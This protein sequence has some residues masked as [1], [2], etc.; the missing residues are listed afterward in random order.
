MIEA[1]ELLRSY[2]QGIRRLSGAKSVSLFVPASLSGL[3][4]PILIHEGESSPVP[5]LADLETA[6]KS[7]QRGALPNRA[8]DK[9]DLHSATLLPSS[10][11]DAA[12]IPLPSVHSVW[13]VALLPE[14]FVQG[15]PQG[16]RRSDDSRSEAEGSPGAWLGIH[17]PPGPGS[18]LERLTRRNLTTEMDEES[19]PAHWWEWL[20]ALGGALASH[21][22][23]ISAILKDPVTG[24]SDRAGFQA[25][26][27]EELSKSRLASR[28]LSLLL[29]NPDEFALVN[30][31]F[32]REA[33]DRIVREISDRLS[34]TLRSSD[35]VARYGG[36]IFG[37][38]LPD[39][40]L[41]DARQV[42]DKI[43]AGVTEAAFLDGAV[44]LGFSIGIAIFDPTEDAVQ[45]PLD[46]IRRADQA[47]NAA[48]RLGGG[49]IIDWEQRSGAEE[50]GNFD[51][52]S[53]IFTGNMT[54]DY[55]NMV[56]LWDTIDVITVNP[57]FQDLASQV[58]EKLYSSFK[59]VRVAL[60]SL[61]DEGQLKLIRGL[62]RKSMEPGAQPRV[63]T[64]E[65]EPEQRELMS[66][67]IA[68]AGPQESRLAEGNQAAYAVPLIASNDCLGCLYLDGWEDSLALDASDL[69]FLKALA[70]QLAVALDR[71][72]L[73]ELES[74]RREQER[75]QLRAELNELRQALQQAKLV[76]RSAEMG[77]LVATARRVAPTDATV[78]IT[79]ASGTGKELLART[80]HEL[81]PRAGKPLVIVDCGAISTTL[82]ESE[83]FGHEKGAYT[84]AQQRRGGRLVEANHGTVLLDEIGDLPLE[85][86]SKLLRFVQEK[87]FTTVGGSRPR[88]VDVRIVTATNQDLAKAVAAGR[89]REDLYYRL[90]VVRLNVPPLAQRPD[91]IVHLARHF[92]ETFTVQYHKNIRQLTPAA[93]QHLLQHPWPG[94]VRELQNRMMQA[95]ILCE[96]DEIG[97][98]EL[99]LPATRE[100]STVPLVATPALAE[101]VPSVPLPDTPPPHSPPGAV[102]ASDQ[103]PLFA[104]LKDLLQRALARQIEGAADAGTGMVLPLGKWLSDDVIL[105]ADAAANGLARRGAAIVGIP[106]T[107]Y[108]RRLQRA[109]AQERAGLSPRSGTWNEVRHILSEI[110]R[111]GD[112]DGRNLLERLQNLLLAE[113]LARFPSEIRKGSG[114]L[115]VTAPTYRRRVSRLSESA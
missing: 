12:L 52:L 95:V 8:A 58:V 61:S 47:L 38:T 75:R 89:F 26:L 9:V 71:A 23:Q 27:S 112:L 83:L 19:D 57:D 72:R 31:R 46:L 10:E 65:L 108:R 60:Y 102:L 18:P 7:V 67:A 73:T 33:G 37:V 42:A 24:L 78:L 53:G 99:G 6:L 77:E 92:L 16:R 29:V 63:E 34:V 13:A 51:R 114:L 25:L 87:Q 21:A 80:I 110:A 66:L 22:S 39:T 104:E 86:Q 48:K 64:V 74:R 76:Y 54:K 113:I 93:E 81:S 5:E 43:L 103:P 106:E 68:E 17:L 98:A 41:D 14:Q 56:T 40:S 30:E 44:R 105:E 84:G 2:V 107:T 94:N 62:T 69:I 115:G 20:F 3:S 85:V 70:S 88:R 45:H 28:P 97:P 82:I 101:S 50:T 1:S 90:N 36:V 35:L 96:A 11:P 4:Q 59:P 91:D 15:R 100:E 111:C 79:G 55:R 109:R 32:G 49:T